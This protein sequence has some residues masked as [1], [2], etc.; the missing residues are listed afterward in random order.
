MASQVTPR[1]TAVVSQFF[2]ADA[3]AAIQISAPKTPEEN[4]NKP[5]MS[6]DRSS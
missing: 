2:A 5:Q 1:L 6:L 3:A 4:T